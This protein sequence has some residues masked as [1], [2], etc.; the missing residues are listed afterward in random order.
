[1]SSSQNLI[2]GEKIAKQSMLL[3]VFATAVKIT[4]AFATGMVVLMADALSS[5]TDMIGI[6]A[7]YIG[8]K[9][10]RKAANKKFEYGY[11]KVETFG[12]LVVSLVIIYLGYE[13]FTRAVESF[14][15]GKEGKLHFIGLITATL[16]I[17]FALYLSRKLGIAGKKTN[18]MSLVENA[19]EKK[20]DV[21]VSIAVIVS[22][23]ADLYNIKYVESVITMAI[24]LMIFKV[25]LG[26]T[27]ESLFFL[28]DYWD[29]PKLVKQ[30][31]NIILKNT[32]IITSIRRIRMRRAGTFI[33]GEVFVEI[34]PFIDANDLRGE[35]EFIDKKIKELDP[36]IKDCTIYTY[37]PKSKK[38]KIGVPISFGRNLTAK[39][40]KSLASTHA[41][42]FVIVK[43]GKVT[44]KYRKK[45]KPSQK[46]AERLT[47]FLNKEKA[48]IIVD[49]GLNSLVYYDLKRYHHIQVYPNFSNTRNVNEAVKLLTIDM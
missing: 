20:I 11:Y 26:S 32:E 37:I 27:K 1:M 7:S 16:S 22:I 6:F 25:G 43:N 10:S 29:D 30:I 9:L 36:Y 23:F 18:S 8:L 17:A 15:A 2:Y 45:L 35:L 41:Y 46:N 28:L 5:V 24:S 47:E 44:E 12:A 21:V 14:Q 49:N 13:V 38:V 33:F 31:R 40:A 3:L 48:N 34:N 39:V 19:L 4:A 42:E